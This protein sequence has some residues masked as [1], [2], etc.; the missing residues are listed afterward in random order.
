MH[1][2]LKKEL[3]LF[4]IFCIASGAMI[5]SGIFILPGLAQG[6]TGPSVFVSYVFAGLLASTGMLSDAELASAMPKA[7]GTY[8]YINRSLGPAIGTIIGLLIWFSL[9]LKSAFALV[10]MSEFAL[11]ILPEGLKLNVSLIGGIFCLFFVGLNLV[12]VKKSGRLQNILV[13]GLLLLLLAYIV[14]GLPAVKVMRFD[15]FAPKGIGAIFSTSGYVFVAYGG[16]LK[17]ASV[18]EETKNPGRTMP[19]GMILALIVI[20]VIYMFT[21]LVTTGVVPHEQLVSSFTPISDG[22]RAIMGT[23]GYIALSIAAMLA[24]I[25]TANAGIMAASR[26]PFS[27]SRDKLLPG[28]ISQVNKRF[29]TPHVSIIITGVFM[30]LSLFLQLD[31]LIKAASSVMILTYLMACVS[32]IILRESRLQNYRPSFKSPLYP[33]LQI[34]GI[35]GFIALL[36]QIDLKPLLISLSFIAAGLIF[37]LLYGKVRSNREYALLHLIERITARAFTGSGLESELKEIIR[38]RDEIVSDRFD[39]VVE[40]AVV[41]DFERA[42]TMSEFFTAAA[43]AL[44]GKIGVDKV[45]LEE[46]LHKREE[47]STTA[48]SNFL[49]IPHVVIEGEKRFDLLIARNREGIRFS[50][51]KESIKAI[52]VLMGTKDERNFHLQSLSAIAQIVQNSTF[53]KRWMSAKN[54]EAL[55]DIVLLGDRSRIR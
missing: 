12:G 17:A 43:E 1:L 21:A 49:A 40:E 48:L 46:C 36:F 29:K 37:Y 38:E 9:A 19:Y 39:H 41:L 33:W 22:A 35:I 23:P 8:F 2:E 34:A 16:L 31:V 55:R 7:G 5:S 44:S 11:L 20:T 52:F 32:I 3:N 25:S 51:S 47:E 45:L 30:T 10:G 24:F 50:E 4:D 26:Y 6:K 27:L 18:A 13:T 15:P 14:K 28:F 53:E 42:M 54:S